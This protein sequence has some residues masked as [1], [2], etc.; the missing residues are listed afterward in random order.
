[1]RQTRQEIQDLVTRHGASAFGYAETPEKV[2]LSFRLEDWVIRVD[3]PTVS[4]KDRAVQYTPGGQWR[5]EQRQAHE[6]EQLKRQRWRAT[7]LVVRAKL[8][9]IES[10]I[11]DVATAF[12]GDIV[13]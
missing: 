4:R 9:A 11:M 1:I 2:S 13:V 8:E 12:L 5:D 3:V 7:L 10:G 6:F